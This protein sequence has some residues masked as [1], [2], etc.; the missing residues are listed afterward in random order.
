M[1][2]RVQMLGSLEAGM[3]NH[4]QILM[5]IIRSEI[6]GETPDLSGFLML[7]E[8]EQKELVK[9]AAHHSVEQF[10]GDALGK[11]PES[12]ELPVM[13]KLL[14]STL[15][16]L[17]Q[18]TKNDLERKKIAQL[19]EEERIPFLPLKGAR[20]R[21]Y[22]PKP[23]MRTSCDIDILVPEAKVEQAAQLL[24]QNLSY[25]LETHNF[26]DVSL[27]SPSGI[28]LELHFSLL[29]NQQPM[30]RVLERVWQYSAPVRAGSMEYA[31]SNEYF[32]FHLTA[33]LVYHLTAGGCGIRPFVDLFVLREML[34]FDEKQ[35]EQ[36]CE[37]AGILTFWHNAW[38]LVDVWF[39]G[40]E[41]TQIT[42]R[43]ERFIL[44]GG[45]FGTAENHI[46]VGKTR[47][48]GKARYLWSHI[49]IPTTVLSVMYP[50]LRTSPWLMPL[51]QVRRWLRVMHW[52]EAKDVWNRVRLVRQEDPDSAADIRTMLQDNGLL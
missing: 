24:V 17:N 37:E 45:T 5:D 12:A 28:H 15:I 6:C 1:K 2:Q 11:N 7:T 21:P 27:F 14:R 39:C 51:Y 50:I 32:L 41:H 31:Q 8:E 10:L 36:L 43:L 35:V 33:H 4:T 40:K 46:A 47:N 3:E 13:R 29:E 44:D 23:W 20:I 42:Q 52:G 26:H 38:Q 34:P 18:V 25:R 9:L 48:G 22:Y 30:D 16:A 49:W 19:F